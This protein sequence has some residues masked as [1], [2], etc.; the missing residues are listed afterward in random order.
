MDRFINLEHGYSG[1]RLLRDLWP[2]RA[3]QINLTIQVASVNILIH[4]AV[5]ATVEVVFTVFTNILVFSA[6]EVVVSASQFVV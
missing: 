1:A 4:F 2:R 6:S 5:C 3:E